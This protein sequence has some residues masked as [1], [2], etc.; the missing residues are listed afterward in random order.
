MRIHSAINGLAAIW[1]VIGSA[2]IAQAPTKSVRIAGAIY[3]GDAPTAIAA[4]QGF[5]AREG[6]RAEIA[7]L[8]SGKESLARLRSG[9]ADFAL[10]ALTPLVLDRL[11]DPTPGGADDPVVLASLA[12]S[13]QLLAMVTTG[14]SSIHGSSDFDGK[15]VAIRRG[16]NTEFVWWLY[17]Q[18]HGIERFAVEPVDLPFAEMPEALAAGQVDAALLWEPWI[19]SLDARLLDAGRKPS[20][21]IDL[22]HIYLGKWVLATTRS[23]ARHGMT[24][25]RS[26]IRAYGRAIDFMEASPERALAAYKRQMQVS[27]GEADV[28]WNALDYE[29]SIDWSLI[30]G[31]QEQLHWAA[32]AGYPTVAEPVRVLGLLEPG[33]LLREWPGKVGIPVS[34]AQSDTP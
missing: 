20:R 1:L 30:A 2:A 18:Y 27:G 17:R 16:T 31:L 6:I 29:L 34:E 10:M 5:F 3:L 12:H 9:Q 22:E 14:D 26:V 15:R 19:S 4:A 23:T 11:A 13:D 7:Y 33:P 28:R 21:R 32:A 8:R 24:L 25:S